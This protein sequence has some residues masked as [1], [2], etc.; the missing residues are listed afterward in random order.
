MRVTL[1]TA[2]AASAMT[3]A[4]GH[5]PDVSA[6]GTQN[7]HVRCVTKTLPSDGTDVSTR[8]L[9]PADS[10]IAEIIIDNNPTNDAGL[11]A[12][13][14]SPGLGTPDTC[15]HSDFRLLGTRF[16]DADYQPGN[17]PY[18]VAQNDR[19]ANRPFMDKFFLSM[20]TVFPIRSGD[21]FELMMDT[22]NG[23]NDVILEICFGVFSS[24][25]PVVL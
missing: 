23:S 14:P 22:A 6:N 11:C 24:R 19:L 13:V 2:L 3:L 16:K 15:T 7:Y 21:N 1:I 4:L 20:D 9:F 10:F 12:F 5:V 18:D 8:A 25:A 17:M